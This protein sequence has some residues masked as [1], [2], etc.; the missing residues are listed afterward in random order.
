VE[1]GRW[2]MGEFFDAALAFP[3]AVF[4]VL[5]IGVVFYWV[6]FLFGLGVDSFDT[7][8]EIDGEPDGFAGFLAF[9]GLGGVP[10]TIIAS[11]VIA[12]GWFVSVVATA[13]MR[14]TEGLLFAVLTVL[15]F[16]AALAGGWLGTWPLARLLRRVL[17]TGPGPAR[18]DFVGRTCVVRTS[19]VSRDFGQAEVTAADGSSAIIQV[20][21][22]DDDPL[23]AGS[24]AVI[25]DYDADGEFF[26]VMPVDVID[27]PPPSSVPKD[28]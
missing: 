9:L 14:R 21:Q 11:L 27:P 28:S 13:A 26:W 4:G 16:A 23:P 5:L 8:T 18:A 15:V 10:V 19:R 25:Y 20:R 2:G 24:G 6:L 22:T 17:A 12:F 7:D 1:E 3:A